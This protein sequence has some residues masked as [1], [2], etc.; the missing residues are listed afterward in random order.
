METARQKLEHGNP[1]R[2]AGYDQNEASIS[3]ASPPGTAPRVVVPRQKIT[4][5]RTGKLQLAATDSARPAMK[6]TFWFSNA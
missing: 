4:I 5:A 1:D 6:A 2:L 3:P